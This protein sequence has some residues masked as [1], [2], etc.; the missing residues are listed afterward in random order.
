[1]MLEM[2]Y[3]AL[4][5]GAKTLAL[6]KA[7]LAISQQETEQCK[8]ALD[9]ALER[10]NHWHDVYVKKSE[11]DRKSRIWV[12]IPWV[13]LVLESGVLAALAIKGGAK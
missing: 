1:M 9:L 11:Q 5:Q 8:K 6:L 2:D 10:G 7:E 3:L 12:H 4:F 13:L